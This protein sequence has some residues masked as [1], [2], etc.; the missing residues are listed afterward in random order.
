MGSQLSLSKVEEVRRQPGRSFLPS[1]FHSSSCPAIHPPTYPSFLLSVFSS[2]CPSNSF[3][4]HLSFCPSSYPPFCLPCH[5][6][7]H[8]LIHPHIH[9]SIHPSFSLPPPPPPPSSS[10]SSFSI[11]SLSSISHHLC[12]WTD[13]D[14]EQQQVSPLPG[15]HRQVYMPTET[16]SPSHRMAGGREGLLEELVEAKALG[17]EWAGPRE[18]PWR[19]GWKAKFEVLGTGL[20]CSMKQ[21]GFR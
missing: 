19:L 6:F 17:L 5:P 9:S 18:G 4:T 2:A 14:P 12:R 8:S 11:C 1:S 21:G 13:K 20:D 16:W 15:A 7:I 10:M 3:T